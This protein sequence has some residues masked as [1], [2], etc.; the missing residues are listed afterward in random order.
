MTSQKRAT[1][2][3]VVFCIA[4]SALMVYGLLREE[5]KERRRV[6]KKE[7]LLKNARRDRNAP[8]KASPAAAVKTPGTK[9]TSK[10]VDMKTP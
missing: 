7:H 1:V 10:P 2:V 3:I 8:R 6:A 9:S 4:F 5:V